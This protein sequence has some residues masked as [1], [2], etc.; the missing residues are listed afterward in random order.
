MF[1][2]FT[3]MKRISKLLSGE[4]KDRVVEIPMMECK[5]CGKVPEFMHRNFQDFPEDMKAIPT[6]VEIPTVP[7]EDRE[8]LQEGVDPEHH[9]EPEQEKK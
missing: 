6:K 5:S 8:R 2:Q 7:A 9:V 3:M 1:S 4:S